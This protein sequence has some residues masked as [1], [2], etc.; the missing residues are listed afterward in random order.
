MSAYYHAMPQGSIF[1][2]DSVQGKII[3]ESCAQPDTKGNRNCAEETPS[4]SVQHDGSS[5]YYGLPRNIFVGLL[6]FIGL[7]LYALKGFHPVED[8]LL[9]IAGAF[10]VG[11]AIFPMAYPP[12]TT[13]QC[14]HWMHFACALT[15]F[16][17]IGVDVVLYS[18][19]TLKL[20]DR[21]RAMAF[22]GARLLKSSNFYRWAY[23]ILGWGMILLP[24]MAFLFNKLS[25]RGVF[26]TEV[27]G[28]WL[29]GIYWLLK[30]HELSVTR[31][32]HEIASANLTLES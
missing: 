24:L 29:F 26:I 20:A 19:I 17:L 6:F 16:L 4:L 7:C 32:E 2:F 9:T 23:R 1:L 10:A 13:W 12:V 8:I 3:D 30:N 28:I 18:G 15:F 25:P 21:H 14:Y 31:V 27:Y 5:F 22:Q 11:V